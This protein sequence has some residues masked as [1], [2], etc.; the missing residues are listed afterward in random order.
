MGVSGYNGTFTVTA[1][2]SGTQFQYTDATSGLAASGSGTVT[3]TGV[4]G[5]AR[6]RLNAFFAR[7]GGFISTNVTSAGFLTGATPS[8]L[9]TG[10]LTQS[11]TSAYGGFVRMDN[12]GTVNSPISGPE[13]S[14]DYYLLPSNITYYSSIPTGAVVDEQYPA[15]ISTLGAA[16]GFV[17]G[18]W[19]TVATPRSTAVNGK[20]MLIHGSTTVGSRYT[21]MATDPTNKIHEQTRVDVPG[22]GRHVDQ[23]DRRDCA[24]RER[25]RAHRQRRYNAGDSLP[26]AWSIDHARHHGPVLD[27]GRDPGQRLVPGRH[28]GRQPEQ[29]E[30]HRHM[31]R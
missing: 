14:Q 29:H 27:L 13:P 30:L 21:F 19:G 26:V 8:P 24:E 1:L 31:R 15:N 28:R 20:P 2:P 22:P 12:P 6:Q 25:H 10:T 16:N 11:N 7:G 23:S 17:S 18:L 9:L 4:N 5:L 3:S